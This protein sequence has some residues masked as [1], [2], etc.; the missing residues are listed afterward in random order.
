MLPWKK[1]AL[2]V[3]LATKPTDVAKLG[4]VVAEIVKKLPQT[5]KQT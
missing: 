1:V 2:K 5:I 4:V 3:R